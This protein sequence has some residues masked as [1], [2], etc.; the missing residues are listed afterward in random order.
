VVHKFNLYNPLYSKAFQLWKQEDVRGDLIEVFKIFKGFE[1][2]EPSKFFSLSQLHRRGH[3]LK[4][5][6]PSKLLNTEACTL[7]AGMDF[8]F[9]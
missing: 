8:W 5:F 3:F 1:N 9:F 7:N 2:F 6:F 4:S